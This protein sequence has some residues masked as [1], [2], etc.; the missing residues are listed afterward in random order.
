MKTNE[1]IN[2]LID[3]AMNSIDNVER[4]APPPFLLTRITARLQ[5]SRENFWEKAGWFI[6]RPKIAI[7]ALVML[8][9]INVMAVVLNKPDSFTVATENPALFPADEFSSTVATLYDIENSEP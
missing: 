8:M 2:K 9:V 1:H 6:A 7:P 4:A 3:E 5:K